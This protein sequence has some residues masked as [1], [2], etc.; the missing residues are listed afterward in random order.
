MLKRRVKNRKTVVP[1]DCRPIAAKHTITEHYDLVYDLEKS[2]GNY[3]YDSLNE[4][5]LLDLVSFY[6]SNPLGYNH[7]ALQDKDFE[8]KLLRAAKTNPNN[9]DFL[10]VEYSTFLQA[11]YKHA[12]PSQFKYV[13]FITAGTLAV[14]NAIK[15]AFDWKMRKSPYIKDPSQMT[16]AYIKKSFHGRS[17]FA[18]NCTS[19]NYTKY[20]N[21]PRL[22]WVELEYSQNTL[23]ELELAMYNED[24]AAVILEPIQSSGGDNFFH[25]SF[26]VGLRDLCNKVDTLLIYDEIQ[27]GVGMTGKF[28]C[29]EHYKVVP[30]IVCFGKKLQVAGFMATSRLD[31]VKEHVFKEPNRL[32]GTFTGTL[33]DM[34]RAT[35]YLEI[36]KKE[37]L[38]KN[39]DKV[40]T[41]LLIQLLNLQNKYPAI[42]NVRGL[43]LLCAFDL[44][45]KQAR[46]KVLEEA[47]N[48]EALLLFGCGE[49]SIRLRPSL[50]FSVAEVDILVKKLD[51]LIG[52]L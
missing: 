31:E 26:H 25:E 27:T 36:I 2:Y 21:F 43:G 46:D 45:D 52:K 14:D 40:G 4:R 32:D 10:T 5:Y 3:L 22:N 42:R 11:F 17:G 8:S 35:K 34:V 16:V 18:L 49:R 24:V 47:L 38:V 1:K 7:P 41:H 39:A 15:T 30:D 37:K 20:K 19:D 50:I 28:W 48:T 44:E 9:S 29:Y 33:V 13:F 51:T 12:M 23:G 6:A